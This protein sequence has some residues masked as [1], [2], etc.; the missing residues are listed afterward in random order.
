MSN[1]VKIKHT[2]LA[3]LSV[4][5]VIGVLAGVSVQAKREKI[6]FITPDT[7]TAEINTSRYTQY[8]EATAIAVD[9]LTTEG[10]VKQLENDNFE[11][12]LR[13][14]SASIRLVDKKSGYVWGE[15][16]TDTVDDLNDFYAAMANSI[17]TVMYYDVGNQN[18]LEQVSMSDES[19]ANTYT[20]DPETNTLYCTSDNY[21][22]GLYFEFQII[23]AEDHL[24]VEVLKD[25]IDEYDIDE[26]GN[27]R[28][29]L[30]QIY[31]LPFFGCTQKGEMDGYIFI[32]DGSGALMRF[33]ANTDNN[34][35]YNAKLYGR[36][37]GV[38]GF[39]ALNPVSSLMAKRTDDYL[40][41]VFRATIPVYGIVHGA[42]QYAAMTVIEGGKEYV[43]IRAALA[44]EITPYNWA[45]A[46]FE[47]RSTYSQPVSKNKNDNIIRPQDTLNN[48]NAKI[49]VYLLSEGEASYSGMAIR[50]RGMLEENGTL[51]DVAKTYEEQIPLRLEVLGSDVKKGFIFDGVQTFTTTEQ[52]LQMQ[53]SLAEKGIKNLTMVMTGWQSGGVNGSTYG[54]YKTQA[55]VGSMSDLEALRDSVINAGGNFYLQAKTMTFTEAQGKT[56]YLAVQSIGRELIGYERKNETV[57]FPINYLVSPRNVM[58]ALQTATVELKGFNLNLPKLG[59][60][61]HSHYEQDASKTAVRTTTRKM[62]ET[63]AEKV[64]KS[65]AQIAMN[66]PNVYM[67]DSCTDYFDIP[68]M[69]SQYL[70]ESDS[71]PFLQIVLKGHINYYAPYA[72]QGFYTT[73]CTLKSIEYGAYPSFLVMGAE[74]GDLNKTPMVDYFSLNFTDWE[75][76]IES[77]YNMVNSA[78]KEV[79]GAKMSEHKVLAEGVVRVSYDNGVKIYI[80]YNSEAV[81]VDD[82]TVE[83][84]NFAMGG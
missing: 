48:F 14:E 41:D 60:E 61:L 16:P 63:A 49:S 35:N 26:K 59:S 44:G 79:E 80:N 64:E 23:L 51:A 10:F 11:L 52:A 46:V 34:S 74:N 67:W 78:L 42:E 54:S 53:S 72:N 70:F 15:L 17:F 55:T 82:V 77:T 37:G 75:G 62:L 66:N 36:D 76:I 13:E 4:L 12:W 33:D 83:G 40:V 28:Y 68:M 47:Y 25:T 24:E 1:M 2:L 57:M 43:S 38:V 73:A 3:A 27:L 69:N 58:S 7:S 56:S 6:Q 32:P 21:D 20:A 50:Y 45:S 84:L 81:T 19:F 31:L 5:L 8:Y 39:D 22:I 9:R 71:V 18:S 30:S 65:G 29:M